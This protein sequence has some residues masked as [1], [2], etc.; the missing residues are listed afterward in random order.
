[1]RRSSV[2]EQSS[3]ATEASVSGAKGG[4]GA[5]ASGGASVSGGSGTGSGAGVWSLVGAA[6]GMSGMPGMVY[7]GSAKGDICMVCGSA[8]P[9][10]SVLWSDSTHESLVGASDSPPSSCTECRVLAFGVP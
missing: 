1:M 3:G 8:S 10:C 4:S 7:C 5:T 2:K 6:A 9:A